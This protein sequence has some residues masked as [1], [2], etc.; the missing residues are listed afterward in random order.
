MTGVRWGHIDGWEGR[1][2]ACAEWLPLDPEFWPVKGRGLRV[3][4]AC[5]QLAARLRRRARLAAPGGLPDER[6]RQRAYRAVARDALNV[7]RREWRAAK[8]ALD[9]AWAERRRTWH[10]EYQRRRRAA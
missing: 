9:P 4:R 1:C 6:V 10:R 7:S 5:D 3:C 8:I 2:D